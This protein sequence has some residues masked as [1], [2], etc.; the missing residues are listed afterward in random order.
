EEY[1][2]PRSFIRLPL[3][4][5]D[6]SRRIITA[7]IA[8]GE[9]EVRIDVIREQKRKI[10]SEYQFF[11]T[12]ARIVH[13]DQLARH[14]DVSVL[15]LDRR[16][17][18]WESFRQSAA[19]MAG[20]VFVERCERVPAVDGEALAMDEGIAYMFRGNDFDYRRGIVGC[21][22]SHLE[23][24]KRAASS[25][26]T[27]LVLE[28]DARFCAGFGG[29][30]VEVCGAL[31][32]LHPGFDVALLGYHH[33]SDRRDGEF[34]ATHRSAELRPMEWNE[35]LGGL[36]AY[37]VSPSGA[38]RLLSLVQRD[39][40]QVAIDWL[41][42]RKSQSGELEV[43]QCVPHIASSPLAPPGSTVDSNIQHDF[44]SVRA[45]LAS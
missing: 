25:G 32:E 38:R 34:R 5:F 6:E 11:P 16:P 37:I 3:E 30:L 29:Q 35:Y 28:D 39:G 43:V 41:V 19:E 36:F 23:T 4:D 18:R 27:A 42:M 33:W 24:W 22:L 14:L 15:N 8:A 1:L 17:D 44:A 10:L 20:S 12:L 7:A 9:R 45:A 13:G 2:D 31:E 40:I 26:R 21:A